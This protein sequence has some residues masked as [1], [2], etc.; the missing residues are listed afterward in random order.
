MAVPL[1]LNQKEYSS[2]M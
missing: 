1:V 2:L